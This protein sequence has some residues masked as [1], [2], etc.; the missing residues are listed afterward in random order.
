MTSNNKRCCGSI[1][2]DS[3]GLNP[4]KDAS[5][6]S[7]FFTKPPWRTVIIPGTWQD[8]TKTSWKLD[9]TKVLKDEN[10]GKTVETNV[11]LASGKHEM[12][13]SENMKFASIFEKGELHE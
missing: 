11:N 10:R 4:K 3:A 7:A 6:Q 8:V 2:F 5:K 1:T 13:G 9:Q 12:L